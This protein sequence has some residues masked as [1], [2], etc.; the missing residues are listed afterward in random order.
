MQITYWDVYDGQV[1][2]N[3]EGS[4][5]AEIN[6]LAIS[7]DGE[8]FASGGADKEVKLWGYDEGHCFAVGRG[9]SGAVLKVGARAESRQKMPAGVDVVVFLFLL[10][11]CLLYD[12]I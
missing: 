10:S 9:H 1:I 3:I 4:K 12:S 5:S 2:R 6:A 11:Y 7:T 8:A